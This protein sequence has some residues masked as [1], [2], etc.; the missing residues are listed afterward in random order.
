VEKK[1][2]KTHKPVIGGILILISGVFGLLGTVNYWIGIGEAGSGFGKGDI[3]PFVPSIIFGLPVPAFIIAI[4]ALVG[5]TLA[6]FRKKWTWSLISAIAAS[7]SF[8]LLGIP[9]LV[10]IA[11]AKDEFS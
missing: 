11:L 8:I 2:N 10:L 9:A 7:L 5:G 6:L 3:P 1:I 4:L